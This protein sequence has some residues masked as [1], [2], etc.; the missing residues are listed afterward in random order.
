MP[1]FLVG[2]ARYDS[3]PSLNL[4]CENIE[5]AF[6]TCENQSG[7]KN[8]R[9]NIYLTDNPNIVEWKSFWNE[10]MYV[11]IELRK[12]LKSFRNICETIQE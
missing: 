10:R 2:S 7:K 4:E 6:L 8:M 9:W 5:D 11:I 1:L 3:Y 12:G